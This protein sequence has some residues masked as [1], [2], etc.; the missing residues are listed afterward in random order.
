M[1]VPHVS[2]PLEVV[3]KNIDSNGSADSIRI[4][5]CEK[6]RSVPLIGAI[7]QMPLSEIRL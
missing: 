2:L 3:V 1:L 7:V 5:I 6:F 4:I